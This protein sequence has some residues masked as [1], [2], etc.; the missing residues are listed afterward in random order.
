M[1]DF[2]SQNDVIL[3]FPSFNE[4]V[5]EWGDDIRKDGF[6]A[7]NE[8]LIGEF[9]NGVAEANGSE[10]A[11]TKRIINFGNGGRVWFGCGGR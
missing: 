5:L 2:L 8:N 1:G 3:D 10:V 9:V 7:I 4:T 11:N 6:E